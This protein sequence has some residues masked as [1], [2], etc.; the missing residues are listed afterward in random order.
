[1]SLRLANLL[2]S[3]EITR[4]SESDLLMDSPVVPI[5]E[6]LLASAWPFTN[7]KC[8][9]FLPLLS[10]WAWFTEVSWPHLPSTDLMFELTVYI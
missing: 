5:T 9:L 8:V 7:V 6:V 4:L 10:P 1:M 3:K 2:K